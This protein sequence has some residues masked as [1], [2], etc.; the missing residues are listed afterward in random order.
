MLL[1]EK[2]PA[3]NAQLLATG[4][5]HL[6]FLGRVSSSRFGKWIALSQYGFPFSF[7]PYS[8]PVAR[9]RGDR[10]SQDGVECRGR[11]QPSQ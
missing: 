7:R 11:P 5:S 10:A 9:W 6:G 3:I 8:S 2:T 4:L 1:A